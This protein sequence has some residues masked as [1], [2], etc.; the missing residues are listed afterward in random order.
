MSCA[1]TL[2]QW[3]IWPQHLTLCSTL[4][5]PAAPPEAYPPWME[6]KDQT[7]VVAKNEVRTSENKHF[8]KGLRQSHSKVLN[9]CSLTCSENNAE[10]G[11]WSLMVKPMWLRYMCCV[12]LVA[13]PNHEVRPRCSEALWVGTGEPVRRRRQRMRS[14]QAGF[15]FFALTQTPKYK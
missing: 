13:P 11:L 5:W 9:W 10:T 8:Y 4:C 1:G 6:T 3:C 15:L 7:Q 14:V 2:M 12:T